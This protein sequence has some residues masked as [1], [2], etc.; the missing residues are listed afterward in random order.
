MLFVL[1]AVLSTVIFLPRIDAAELPREGI[2]T[3]P[4]GVSEP[5]VGLWSVGF[6]EGDGMISGATI[7]SCEAPVALAGTDKG[8][9]AYRAPTGDEVIFA[10]S[11]FSGRTTWFPAL[12]ESLVAVWV[13]EDEFYLYS[14]NPTTGRGHWNN[15]HAY[16]RCR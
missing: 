5:F 8:T 11:E 10:L 4:N 12:G 9:L 7:A 16:R 6:L 14:I 3:I 13:G 1:V 2:S 15:P